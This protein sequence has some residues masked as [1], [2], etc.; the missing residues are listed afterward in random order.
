MPSCRHSRRG[1]SGAP[2]HPRTG[3]ATTAAVR[4]FQ[5]D[6]GLDEDGA[7]GPRTEAS[8]NW[9]SLFPGVMA[10][11]RWGGEVH[12]RRGGRQRSDVVQQ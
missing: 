10:P 3:P 12:G 9:I 7:Y 1:G 11:S 4:G 5:R 2:P 8:R 6:N